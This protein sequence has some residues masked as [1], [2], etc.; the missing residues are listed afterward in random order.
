MSSYRD[1]RMQRRF[2]VFLGVLL[3][4]AMAGSVLL[5]L[6]QPQISQIPPELPTP[7]SPPVIPTPIADLQ[8]INFSQ[9][10]LHPAGLFTASL[11][12]GWTTASEF[13]TTS[14]AQSTFRNAEAQSVIEV[15]LIQAGENLQTAEEVSAYFNDTW[16]AASWR[17]Y[18][19]W[20]ERT[21]STNDNKVMIDFSLR[22]GLV[23]YI[24]R[25]EAYSDGNWV[26]V[27]RVV[28]PANASGMLV[29]LLDQVSASL[30]PNN[31]FVGTPLNWKA[32]F[33]Q[34]DKHILRYPDGWTLTDAAAGVS[35]SLESDAGAVRLEA[36][37]AVVAS[38]SDA[39]AFVSAS[40][41]GASILST[42]AIERNGFR[43]FSVAYS[44]PSA[45]GPAF[46][47]LAVLLNGPD[48]RVHSAFLRS[49]L[50]GVDFNSDEA[51]S[52]SGDLLQ[53]MS[54]FT[55]LPDVGSNS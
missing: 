51:A 45:D 50:S 22:R 9:A 31:Q 52:I 39:E 16:L 24:A 42:E 18:T 32:Y 44:L 37:N 27:T 6:F 5:P 43:G 26:Y 13:N 7:T 41:P 25:H 15:R 35:A 46:S 30:T 53:M 14:E 34:S 4:F 12:E 55:L 28:T 29:Y 33:D 1:T 3:I 8:S 23:D 38:E 54:T 20:N 47:G 19:A 11:P 2:T 49:R 10:Y 17:E 21:R 36:A 48:E 40:L